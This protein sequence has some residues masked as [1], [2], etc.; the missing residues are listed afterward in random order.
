MQFL[1][2]ALDCYF[3]AVLGTA[4]LA[5]MDDP[6]PFAATLRRQHLLPT[7]SVG[8]IGRLLPSLE[9]AMA[10]ALL[11]SIAAIPV[12][13]FT[14]LIFAGFLVVQIL[15][16]ATRHGSDCGC[17]GPAS[18]HRIEGASIATASLLLMLAGI[19]LW[20]VIET[21]AIAW[22]WRLAIGVLGAV[23]GSRLGWRTWQRRR[24]ARCLQRP[25]RMPLQVWIRSRG[26][27]HPISREER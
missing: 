6:A 16:L 1:T 19:H 14:V 2:L 26:G 9:I 27:G 18:S 23:A 3:A 20:L 21:T 12:A 17:Y 15:L 5:K 4:G 13:T 25:A 24:S 11:S 7:W 10:G 22:H 8:T